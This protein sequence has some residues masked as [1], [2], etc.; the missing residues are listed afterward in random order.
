MPIR[1]ESADS[2]AELRL[3]PYLVS[4]LTAF[5]GTLAAPAMA[6]V[7]YVID[8]VQSQISIGSATF[9][10]TSGP[11]FVTDLVP[12][13]P[14]TLS[15]SVSGTVLADPTNA[16][17]EG[18]TLVVGG[19]PLVADQV[20]DNAAGMAIDLGDVVLTGLALTI[21][22][23]NTATISSGVVDY[24]VSLGSARNTTS[25]PRDLSGDASAF[26]NTG[27]P[28]VFTMSGGVEQVMIPILVDIVDL[29]ALPGASVSFTISGTVVPEPAT[30]T[31][32][33]AGLASLLW[34]ARRKSHARP[35][36][37]HGSPSRRRRS[38]ALLA[39]SLL[40]VVST[41]CPEL[42][43]AAEDEDTLPPV[44]AIDDTAST[45]SG[46]SVDIRVLANDLFDDYLITSF[47]QATDQ[48]GTLQ[49][50]SVDNDFEFSPFVEILVY[51]PPPG[52]VGTVTFTYEIFG[53]GD[54]Y[55]FS[56]RDT[57]TVTVTVSE[58][59]PNVDAV[60][61]VAS[62]TEDQVVVVD[63]L[64]NDSQDADTILS[65][66][67]AV[68]GGGNLQPGSVSRA[69]GPVEQ[70]A[71]Q[72]PTGFTGTADF[73]YTIEGAGNAFLAGS[74]DTATV[75]IDVQ[76]QSTGDARVQFRENTSSLQFIELGW[77][78]V[79]QA[80]ITNDVHS[81]MIF[82]LGEVTS[83]VNVTAD[84]NV[85]LRARLLENTEVIVDGVCPQFAS[86]SDYTVVVQDAA[87][88]GFEILC[89]PGLFDAALC[90]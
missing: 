20:L 19:A 88:G 10:T 79:T 4:C 78:F 7:S 43:E 70:L 63:V 58:A 65:F 8:S 37:P 32:L 50:N 84:S 33:V 73:D 52:F 27:G 5:S 17:V 12:V 87:G 90:P 53:F 21:D 51:T 54:E 59:L 86:G 35:P 72:P 6:G 36:P 85:A 18:A 16:T 24:S 22:D 31:A 1:S 28:P 69:P 61:D 49:P 81:A 74:S 46:Q 77:F 14:D 67:D 15:R 38:L 45:A 2:I 39:L 30:G 64:M 26:A 47:T 48:T 71:Y 11:A 23:T 57:G 60:D 40:V 9:Q 3:L 25:I 75:Q 44:D 41:G 55:D 34:V 29:P 66:T 89:T 42:E 83:C 82:Q 80:N 76:P 68:D 62:T 56:S 13:A